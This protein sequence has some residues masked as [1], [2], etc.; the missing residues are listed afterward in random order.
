MPNGVCEYKRVTY[1][2][3][4]PCNANVSMHYTV[5]LRSCICNRS[6]AA[7]TSEPTRSSNFHIWSSHDVLVDVHISHTD[8]GWARA[9]S[10]C[11][12]GCLFQA[13]VETTRAFP[14]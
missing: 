8:S 5:R 10:P 13:R 7:C 9:D 12:K 11:G 1:T 6:A 14:D 2:V 3:T 4:N